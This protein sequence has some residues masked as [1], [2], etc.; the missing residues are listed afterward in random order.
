[1]RILRSYTGDDGQTHF[2]A[3]APVLHEAAHGRLSALAPA[4]GMIFRETTRCA[5]LG[6]R[7]PPRRQFVVI[8]AGVV[9]LEGG[10]GRRHRLHPGDV[11]FAE[12]TTGK[13]HIVRDVEVPRRSLFIPVPADFDL[14][15]WLAGNA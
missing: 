15:A 13:G 2:E 14:A 7:N 12:A 5:D 10:D 6:H 1:M 4:T 8:L 3:L 9:E 11:L